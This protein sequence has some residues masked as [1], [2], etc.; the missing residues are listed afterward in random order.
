[1]H[2]RAVAMHDGIC[3][4]GGGAW[5]REGEKALGKRFP[6]IPLG[7]SVPEKRGLGRVT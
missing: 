1:M 7:W 5:S 6:R 3:G 4:G 2:V